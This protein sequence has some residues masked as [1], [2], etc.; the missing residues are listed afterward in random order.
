MSIPG[1]ISESSLRR[2]DERLLPDREQITSG[3]AVITPQLLRFGV[4]QQEYGCYLSCRG[5]G[6]PRG[7]CEFFCFSGGRAPVF[8]FLP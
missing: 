6:A 1:F 4:S 2:T 3:A 8:T 5:N 7:I